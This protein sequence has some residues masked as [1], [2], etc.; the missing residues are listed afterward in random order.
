[1]NF[2]PFYAAEDFGYFSREGLSIHCI[3]VKEDKKTKVKFAL[4]GDLAFYTSISTT[5]EAL[6]RAWGNVRALCS[7]QTTF[8]F[9]VARPEIKDLRDL[10][11]KKVMVGGGASNNQI[12]YLSKKMGW[13]PQ[14]DITI[15]PSDALGRIKAF[16]DPNISAVI[17]REEYVYWG[18]KAGWHPI[19]YPEEYMR[20]YAGGL[21]TSERLIREQPETAF[22]A[23]KA[24]YQATLHINSDRREAV[25]LAVKRISHLSPE[26]AEGNYDVHQRHGGYSCTI[27]E[28][29]I[30]FMS[31]VL[32]MAKGVDR[33]ITLRQVAD[34]SFLERV[35]AAGQQQ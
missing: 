9:C 4:E 18:E 26:E 2:L 34:L 19:R 22:K 15:V 6:L 32:G 20:W 35:Q 25:E 1:M 33:K 5:V 27:A 13:D 24:L 16:Q 8:H 23:V 30:R 3:H 17:A 12:L 7:N 29:G 28:E 21:C 14:K 11:G 31:E 10:K